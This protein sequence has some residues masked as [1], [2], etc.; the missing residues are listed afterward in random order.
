MRKA[1]WA[2]PV[3]VAYVF[4]LNIDGRLIV[5]SDMPRVLR[6]STGSAFRVANTNVLRFAAPPL[7]SAASLLAATPVG[8]DD[9]NEPVQLFYLCLAAPVRL[10]TSH[11]RASADRRRPG[12]NFNH[13]KSRPGPIGGI[14]SWS[15]YLLRHNQR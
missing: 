6:R 7:W 9:R 5:R 1:P 15:M 4:M 8:R 12:L 10:A 3:L 2:G 13:K 14:P 11:H